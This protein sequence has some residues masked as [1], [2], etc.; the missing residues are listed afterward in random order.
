MRRLNPI[1]SDSPLKTRPGLVAIAM[2]GG[3]LTF[4]I[5][6]VPTCQGQESGQLH[7]QN[8]IYSPVITTPPDA[9]AR[10][11]M[12]EKQTK[13]QNFDAVNAER[14]RQLDDDT[15][16]LLKLATE[17]KAEIA[18]SGSATL[19]VDE[20]QKAE[21]IEKL[22]NGVKEKMKLTVGAS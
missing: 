9:N 16:R 17:L 15:L 11:Q 13:R 7:P 18:E 21:L 2:A 22:A 12:R 20:I 5:A 1:R 19:S 6:A 14:K 4:A 8:S 10:M 3:L